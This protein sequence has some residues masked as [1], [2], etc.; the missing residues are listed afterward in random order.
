MA[1]SVELVLDDRADTLV[2]RQWDLLADHGLPSARRANPD[3]HHR[4]HVTLFAAV[5]LDPTVDQGLPGL[6]ATHDVVGLPLL[7]GP[8]T[9]FGPPARRG[10]R[11]GSYVLVRAVAVSAPLLRLQRAVA[12]LC[13]ADPDGTFADGRWLPHVTLARRVAPD[14]VG[15]ALTVLAAEPEPILARVARCRRWDGDT[16]S[17]WWLEPDTS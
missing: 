3:P 7:I 4:P 14:Q 12:D 11:P 13:G 16:R 5:T 6:V 1:Q 15:A 8:P 9:L 17:A 10:K 2:R